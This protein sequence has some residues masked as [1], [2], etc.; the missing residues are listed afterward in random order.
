MELGVSYIPWNK[1][2]NI[3]DQDLELLEEGGM[4]DEDT[5]PPNL[6]GIFLL[7]LYIYIKVIKIIYK[8][9]IIGQRK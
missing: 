4:I 8:I 9:W 6:K 2:I 3:T 7:F 5:L 1:L